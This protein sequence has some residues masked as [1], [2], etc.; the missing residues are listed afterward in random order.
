MVQS[1]RLGIFL[2]IK[3]LVGAEEQGACFFLKV[4]GRFMKSILVHGCPDDRNLGGNRRGDFAAV[5]RLLDGFLFARRFDR[6]RG[7][8]CS[9]FGD[10]FGIQDAQ[11]KD[12]LLGL[13]LAVG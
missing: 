4:G 12:I 3:I 9:L 13:F 1:S 7:R 11:P 10:L 5:G 8:P 6:G 2:R